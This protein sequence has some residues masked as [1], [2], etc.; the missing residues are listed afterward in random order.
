MSTL[1]D[2]ES[3]KVNDGDWSGRAEQLLQQQLKSVQEECRCEIYLIVG[4]VHTLSVVYR[5]LREAYRR[6]GSSSRLSRY[7][8]VSP[9]V[10]NTNYTD[11]I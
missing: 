8:R 7:S 9:S 6:E 5:Q 11:M 1:G 10:I 3:N 2:V 4:C